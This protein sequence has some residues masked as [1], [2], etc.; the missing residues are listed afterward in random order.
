MLSYID[1]YGYTV[2][3][4]AQMVHLKRELVDVMPLCVNQS[5]RDLIAQIQALVE[6]GIATP[7]QYLVF[8]GD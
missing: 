2:F 7:L 6:T 8:D 5:E 1:W 3:N 4:H